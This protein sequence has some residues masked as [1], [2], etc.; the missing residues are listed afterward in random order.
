VRAAVL[1][2]ALVLLPSVAT[3]QTSENLLLVIN[4][5]IPQ[6]IQIA[7]HYIA[8]RHVPDRNVIRIKTTV[9]DTIS[10]AQYV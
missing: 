7:D 10:R 9:D 1:L 5:N 4:T 3:A 2:A 8:V 6:S